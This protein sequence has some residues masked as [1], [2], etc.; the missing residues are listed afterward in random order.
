MTQ[1]LKK[2][3]SDSGYTQK[4][5]A[6]RL[7]TTQQT[8]AR[9]ESGQVAIPTPMLKDIAALFN[10][11][12][13]ELLGVKLRSSQRRA[14]KFALAKHDTPAGTLKVAF[15]FGEREYPISESL[16]DSLKDGLNL[17]G[18]EGWIA[19]S[20]LDNRL[21]L[22]NPAAIRTISY[23]CDDGEAVGFFV[24]PEAYRY[25][26]AF[27]SPAEEL[28]SFVAGEVQQLLEA[29]APGGNDE[30]AARDAVREELNSVRVIHSDG[31]ER[32][33]LLSESVA[34]S[35]SGLEYR[36]AIRANAFLTVF[37]DGNDV[38]FMNLSSVAVIEVPLEAYLGHLSKMAEEDGC[39]DDVGDEN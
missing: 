5:L 3:R 25:L 12:I 23:V 13:D 34:Y 36:A 1:I 24:S 39:Y 9:W 29:L 11:S 30:H 2:L 31:T 27:D 32:S 26:T 28:G 17:E 21:V 37:D 19:F 15:G 35:V 7:K 16:R 4:Q 33:F 6:E 38:D 18:N 8:I 14:F 10:R 20:A 22:A